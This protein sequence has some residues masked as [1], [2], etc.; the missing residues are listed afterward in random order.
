MADALS[1]SGI[2][3]WHLGRHPEADDSP[4]RRA[5]ALPRRRRP[6]RGGEGAQQP[7][8]DPP[9]PRLSPGRARRLPGVAA[10]IPGD[11]R[12]AERGDPATTTS[13]ASTITRAATRKRLPPAGRRWRY[14]ASIGDLPDEADVLNDIG[15]IYQSAACYDEALVHHQKARLIAEEIG[16]LSQQLIALRR[17][18]DIH[19]GS[20]RYGEALDH[21]QH[22]PAAGP[23]DRR[24]LR[25]RQ[26]PRGHR[27][28]DAQHPAARARRGSCSGRRWTSSNGS[29]CPRQSR[30]GFASRPWTRP[31]AVAHLLAGGPPPAP[32]LPAVT[33]GARQASRRRQARRPGWQ[34]TIAAAVPPAARGAGQ[35]AAR[36]QRRIPSYREVS[37]G[38]NQDR[39]RSGISL[40]YSWSRPVARPRPRPGAGA[41]ASPR[42]WPC[43]AARWR[44]RTSGGFAAD[45]GCAPAGR[46][47]RAMT[48]SPWTAC[49]PAP[50]S[51]SR[52]STARTALGPP[53]R[54]LRHVRREIEAY[55]HL[56][57]HPG[58]AGLRR[59]GGLA[60][61][62][63]MHRAAVLARAC[64]C[65]TA[66]RSPRRR[67]SP[68]SRSR[69]CA[70]RRTAA[71]SGR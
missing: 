40:A 66:A 61:Q 20:G 64:G 45:L 34:H 21:Y 71:G 16:N 48:R 26:D 32:G 41:E 25:G 3:C 47:L 50:S 53:D 60:E 5:V 57:A 1:H 28:I 38:L 65:A 59:A 54:R 11:R 14:T 22:R 63:A 39:I 62:L 55:G 19:R 44:R 68:P 7:G 23:G 36:A 52:C 43:P 56:P 18:A 8:Q 67:T 4:A 13:A 31:A 46:S 30:R 27:R 24:P 42:S 58:R 29:A 35:P 10:D 2:A 17:I 15:A 69:T 6:A 12:S 51:S 37:V 9:V 70:R 49:W 33:W